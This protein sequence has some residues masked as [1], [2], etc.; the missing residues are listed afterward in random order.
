MIGDGR[1]GSFRRWLGRLGRAAVA[2]SLIAW[3]YGRGAIDPSFLTRVVTDP[4]LASVTLVVWLVVHVALAAARWRM[5]VRATGG[6]LAWRAAVQNQTVALF[7]NTTVPA[8]MSGDVWKALVGTPDRRRWALQLGLLTVERLAGACG[9][10]GVLALLASA[11]VGGVIGFGC[12]LLGLMG[13][14]LALWTASRTDGAAHR[15]APWIPRRRHAALRTAVLGALG[16]SLASYV[17]IV[18]AALVIVARL[19]PVGDP[20]PVARACAMAVFVGA[21]PIT[22]GGIGVGHVLLDHLLTALGHA[23]GADAYNLMIL[24]QLA[25]NLLGGLVWPLRS[26]DGGGSPGPDAGSVPELLDL[27]AD[28]SHGEEIVPRQE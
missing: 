11:E 21:V 19:E 7:L 25:L 1:A 16:V 22:P 3:L 28:P 26:P 23:H 17:L 13:G 10:A 18:G 24:P 2:V 9:I 8:G 4:V 5:L 6:E 15:L 12:A 27:H 14:V 20:I